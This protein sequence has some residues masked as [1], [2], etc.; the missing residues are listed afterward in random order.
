VPLRRSFVG[1]SLRRGAPHPPHG[2]SSLGPRRGQRSPLCRRVP[3]ASP[4]SAHSERSAVPALQLGAVRGRAQ[5][6]CTNPSSRFGNRHRERYGPAYGLRARYPGGGAFAAPC[7]VAHSQRLVQRTPPVCRV[8]TARLDEGPAQPIRRPRRSKVAAA[9]PTRPFASWRAMRELMAAGRCA[10]SVSWSI[11][12]NYARALRW[13]VR[14]DL[15]PN[16]APASEFS[17]DFPQDDEN[18]QKVQKPQPLVADLAGV[19]AATEYHRP[20]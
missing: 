7:P 5:G 2:N 17:T 20:W 3:R 10:A 4:T 8:C 19:Q 12:P 13:T 6:P 18:G 15:H 14:P 16:G 9:Q 11:I 1:A